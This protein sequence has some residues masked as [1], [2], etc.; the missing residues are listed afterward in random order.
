M[1]KFSDKLRNKLKHTMILI[2]VVA[3]SLLVFY[4]I[5]SKNGLIA[6]KEKTVTST[7]VA[8]EFKQISELAAYKYNYTDV[9]YFKDSSKYNG[10]T[11][12]L[13]QK[14]FLVKYS[15]YV[16]AGVDLND[17]VIKISEDKHSIEVKLKNSKVL[18]NV[19]DVNSTTILDEKSA[20]FNKLQS[21]EIIDELN[22]NKKEI[23][24]KLIS[25]GFLKKSD[26]NI[27]KLL[28]EI[29]KNMGFKNISIKYNN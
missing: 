6:K 2:L 16:K 7:V 27:T 9:I 23:E 14:T 25:D 5:L 22:K 10:F 28:H 24:T 19:I 11:I 1:G 17:A 18:D 8:N 15:G 13:T 21:Q 3:I 26:E 12:P 29:L 4:G 20:L